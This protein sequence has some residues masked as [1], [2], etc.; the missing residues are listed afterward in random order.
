V[1][2]KA[3]CLKGRDYFPTQS[4]QLETDILFGLLNPFKC[5][6]EFHGHCYL[7]NCLKMVLKISKREE[8]I[9]GCT[10]KQQARKIRVMDFLL[11]RW[12]C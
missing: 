10:G 12:N 5:F 3:V 1:F 7:T 9:L 11:H 6:V 8:K 4:V 2:Q